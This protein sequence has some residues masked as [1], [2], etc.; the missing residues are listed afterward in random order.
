MNRITS[1]GGF[2]ALFYIWYH[3]K[4]WTIT[5]NE[6]N[7]VSPYLV[8]ILKTIPNF[9]VSIMIVVMLIFL[10]FNFLFNRRIFIISISCRILVFVLFMIGLNMLMLEETTTL[11]LLKINHPI[12]LEYKYKYFISMLEE[13]IQTN[14][15]VILPEITA[16]INTLI[17]PEFM[18]K[19]KTLNV[20]QMNDV[21]IETLKSL[22]QVRNEMLMKENMVEESSLRTRGLLFTFLTTII[23]LITRHVN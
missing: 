7:I 18:L 15:L 8:N 11:Y 2:L 16:K 17:T 20:K 12:S 4:E 21:V 23:I 22:N 3:Y 14:K 1:L 10:I 19:L 9:M 6:T 5:A 13:S